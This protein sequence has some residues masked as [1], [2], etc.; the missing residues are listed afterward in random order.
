MYNKNIV[1]KDVRYQ[2]VAYLRKF[3][4]DEDDEESKG[5]IV[6]LNLTSNWAAAQK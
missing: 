3:P 5:E 2:Y 4:E 6:K 1:S